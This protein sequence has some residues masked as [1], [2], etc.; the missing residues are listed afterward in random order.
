MYISIPIIIVVGGV[1]TIF[2]NIKYYIFT[3]LFGQFFVV[4]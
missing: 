1:P 3:Q 4:V 2:D